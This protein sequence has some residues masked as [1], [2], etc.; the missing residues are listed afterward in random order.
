[1]LQYLRFV[2][3]LQRIH[4]FW[5][6]T[7]SNRVTVSQSSEAMCRLHVQASSP[8]RSRIVWV[9]IDVIRNMQVL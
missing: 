3:P 6:I 1:M 9:H 7:L 8:S 4:A 5:A 2:Q